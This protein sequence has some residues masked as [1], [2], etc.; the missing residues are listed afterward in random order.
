MVV[1]WLMPHVHTRGSRHTCWLPAGSGGG[2]VPAHFLCPITHQL[3]F[4]PVL[5]ADGFCYEAS[6]I[7]R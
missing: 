4:D 3:M 7:S 5:A 6:A 2:S 1:R